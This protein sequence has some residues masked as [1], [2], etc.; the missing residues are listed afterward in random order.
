[1]STLFARWTRLMPPTLTPAHV[2]AD[3][4][5]HGLDPQEVRGLINTLNQDLGVAFAAEC[6]QGSAWDSPAGAGGS[7]DRDEQTT[8]A[9]ASFHFRALC[10]CALPVEGLSVP[11]RVYY[12]A[13]YT[14]G[15]LTASLFRSTRSSTIVPTAST[16][17]GGVRSNRKASAP[18]RGSAWR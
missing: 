1:M 5:R 4:R 16:H 11:D 10:I 2:D 12:S 7:R 18:A 3:L 8:G 9:A 14:F 15:P 17:P 13:R 6:S